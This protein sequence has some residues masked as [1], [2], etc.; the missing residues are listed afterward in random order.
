MTRRSAIVPIA[1]GIAQGR[2]CWRQGTRTTRAGWRGWRGLAPALALA[3]LGIPAGAELPPAA[4]VGSFR[5]A[6]GEIV[7]GGPFQER[8]DGPM[9]FLYMDTEGLERAALFERESDLLLRSVQPPGLALEVVPGADGHVDSVIWRGA[10]GPIAGRRVFPHREHALPVSAPDGTD[11]TTRL[12][13]PDCPGP[14]PLVVLVGG[15]GPTTR[16]AGTFETFFLQLGMAVLVYDKRGVGATDWHEPD[17][18]TLAGDAAAVVRAGAALPE[19]DAERVGIWASSQGGWVAPITATEVALDFLLVRA[20]PGVSEMEAHLHEVRQEM[21]AEGLTGLGLDHASALRR[22]IYSLAVTG[23]S[24]A[25]TDAR[26]APYLEK[27]WYRV[28]FG[29]GPVSGTWS[30]WW[31]GWVRRNMAVAP[32]PY[33]ETLDVPIL[34][35][36]GENDENVPL[37]PSRSSLEAAFGVSPGS[38]ETLVV[39]GDTN[40]AFFSQ[41]PDGGFRYVD[42]FFDRM[43]EWLAARGF[44]APECWHGGGSPERAE[45]AG[46]TARQ[47]YPPLELDPSRGG[48]YLRASVTQVVG[49]LPDRFPKDLAV[50]AQDVVHS[51]GG[52]LAVVSGV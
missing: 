47:G 39:L 12:L 30:E 1:R 28:A 9:R 34:W 13:V 11:L 6:T 17:L 52:W 51:S 36:L 40:H 10:D 38:D 3:A 33:L 23:A 32:G 41:R 48:F 22:E 5:L 49:P 15:S 20:G 29:E 19:I 25:G 21:R 46:G 31:W 27:E 50:T 7:T 43:A 44:T 42:G 14:H 18:S 37:V 16:W 8:V 4:F 26:V 24:L 35:F 2:H 45:G